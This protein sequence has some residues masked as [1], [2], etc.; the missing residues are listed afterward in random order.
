VLPVTADTSVNFVARRVANSL[1]LSGAR[2]APVL[3][4]LAWNTSFFWDGG[5]KTLE[6]QAIGP[7]T[8][9]LEMDM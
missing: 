9:P 4:N 8:N 6:Q 7:I 2:N 1:G 5:V 3:V